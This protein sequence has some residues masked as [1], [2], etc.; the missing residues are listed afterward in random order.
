MPEIKPTICLIARWRRGQNPYL[1]NPVEIVWDG[2]GPATLDDYIEHQGCSHQYLRDQKTGAVEIRL[3]PEIVADVRWDATVGAW[4]VSGPCVNP[5]TLPY[6]NRHAK[7]DQIIGALFRFPI[8]YRAR[9]FRGNE[10]N[11]PVCE[12]GRRIRIRPPKGNDCRRRSH[13]AVYYRL[14]RPDSITS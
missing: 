7:D 10:T 9:I 1:D 4:V 13:P 5:A 11:P 2:Q 3:W 8:V 12:V 6:L 14:C